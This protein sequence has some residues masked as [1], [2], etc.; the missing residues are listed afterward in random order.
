MG[1]GRHV[2]ARL[3]I[4]NR[5]TETE[6][7]GAGHVRLELRERDAEVVRHVQRRD[8][9]TLILESCRRPVQGHARGQ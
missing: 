1:L 5:L 7:L 6:V 3:Q 8:E 4:L 2:G 9:L